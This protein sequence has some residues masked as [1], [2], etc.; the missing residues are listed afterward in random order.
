MQW[1]L[2]ALRN[3]VGF[4]GRARRK[5]YWFFQL[6]Y[7]LGGLFISAPFWI[8]ALTWIA[9]GTTPDLSGGLAL[10]T[11]EIVLGILSLLWGL[12]HLLPLI[13]VTVRRLHDTGRSGL[14]YLLAIFLPVI[15]PIWLLVLTVLDSE[16]GENKYGANPKE[17]LAW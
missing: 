1:Y 11:P 3:Y 4:E 5:E 7:G 8:V 17:A 6:F 9:T 13:A 10:G 15:G 2:K 16:P 14:W 12:I